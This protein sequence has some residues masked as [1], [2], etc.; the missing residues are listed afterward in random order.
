LDHHHGQREHGNEN[1]SNLYLR[2]Q[3]RYILQ[4]HM[5]VLLVLCMWPTP[6]CPFFLVPAAGFLTAPPFIWLQLEHIYAYSIQISCTS[7]HALCKYRMRF[8]SSEIGGCATQDN[9]VERK[10]FGSG[11]KREST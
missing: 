8:C 3:H 1:E 9:D 10:P 4:A 2:N 7:T 6:S 5:F 11:V